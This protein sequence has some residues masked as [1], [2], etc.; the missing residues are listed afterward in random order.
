M[1]TVL[2]KSWF[3]PKF[4]KIVNDCNKKVI[5]FSGGKGSPASC[6]NI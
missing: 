2:T 3:Y 4:Y 6:N 1:Q 5:V